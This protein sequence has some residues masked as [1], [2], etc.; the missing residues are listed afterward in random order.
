MNLDP[1]G[2]WNDEEIWKVAEEVTAVQCYLSPSGDVI[3][4]GCCV[5]QMI[6]IFYIYV[7]SYETSAGERLCCATNHIYYLLYK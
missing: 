6:V 1:Y 3:T 5:G 7:E 2:Q 4:A